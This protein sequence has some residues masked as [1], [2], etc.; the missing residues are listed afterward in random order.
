MTAE[1]YSVEQALRRSHLLKSVSGRN[2]YHEC[3]VYQC[4]MLRSIRART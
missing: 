1:N 3:I 2:T 4:K